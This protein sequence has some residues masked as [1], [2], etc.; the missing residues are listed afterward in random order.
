MFKK[1][2]ASAGIGSAKVDTILDKDQFT[3]GGNVTGIVK[4]QGGK[5]DQHIDRINLFLMAEAVHERDDKKF[6]EKVKLQEYT[7]TDSFIINGGESKEFN[8][9]FVLPINTPPTIGWTK[10][11]IQTGLDISQSVDPKDQDYLKV[12][13]HP[14]VETILGALTKELGFYLGKVEMEY[15]KRHGYVQEFE[16]TPTSEYRSD[17]D[18]L[19]AIFFV[20]DNQVNLVLQVDRRAKGL[21][22]LFAEALETDE[23]HVRVSF[24]NNEI[25]N[26]SR[27]I[28]DELRG[29]IKGI[30]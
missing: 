4:V 10:I 27:Y 5:T 17:L 29:I 15:S 23:S 21:D 19:E 6:Y 7:L 30:I 14:Y 2:L 13:P 28:A 12:K 3:P 24:S 9:A 26:G 20:R 11:W 1:L 8:F 22:G 18:E 25:A 16:F